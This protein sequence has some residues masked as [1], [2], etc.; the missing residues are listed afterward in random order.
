ME[1]LAVITTGVIKEVKEGFRME[2]RTEKVEI[3]TNMYS[4][5]V[6]C[7]LDPGRSDISVHNKSDL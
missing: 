7:Q 1:Q 3:K 6:A 5:F 2:L 4:F